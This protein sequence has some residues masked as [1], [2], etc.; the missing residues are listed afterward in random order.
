MPKPFVV[1]LVHFF[2]RAMS[3][4]ANKEQ[5]LKQFDSIVKGIVD[6]KER[7]GKPS[8]CPPS[9]RPPCNWLYVFP[10]LPLVSCFFMLDTNSRDTGCVFPRLSLVI[11]FPRLTLGFI[12]LPRIVIG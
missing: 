12:L 7:V 11:F 2:F 5:F 4:P 1:M 9:P 8:T 3:S 6:N 10:R